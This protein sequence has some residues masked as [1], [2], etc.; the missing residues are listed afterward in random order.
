MF[1]NELFEKDFYEPNP[2]AERNQH[3]I[4]KIYWTHTYYPHEDLQL[5][6]PCPD[7]FDTATKTIATKFRI[8]SAKEDKFDSLTLG[9]PPLKSNEE[10]I[11][12]RAKMRPV[13]MLLPQIEINEIKPLKRGAKIWRPRCLVAQVFSVADKESNN[14]KLPEEF[15]DNIK[16]LQYPQLLFL[17][18]S[19]GIFEVD[20]I[21]RLDECQSVFTS[22]LKPADFRLSPTLRDL[23][24]SQFS[25]LLNKE[26]K[27][28][29]KEVKEFLGTE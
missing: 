27:C 16:K 15:I 18:K 29:Y 21:A 25:F 28:Y 17:P 12:I 6:R 1:I 14:L 23:L 2:L 10:F 26:D 4:G 20:G 8:E 24:K 22:H 19:A 7:G 9:V 13:L 3:S 5:W 11:V